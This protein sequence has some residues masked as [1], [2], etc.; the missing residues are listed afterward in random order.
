MGSL[1]LN[2]NCVQHVPRQKHRQ[3]LR[4]IGWNPVAVFCLIELPVMK[5]PYTATSSIFCK[6]KNIV[7]LLD[8]IKSRTDTPSMQSGRFRVLASI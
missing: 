4:E 1:I 6:I 2:N 5:T 3:G 7:L 8:V